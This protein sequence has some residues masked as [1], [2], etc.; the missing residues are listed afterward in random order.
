MGSSECPLTICAVREPTH[1][2]AF[3]LASSILYQPLRAPLPPQPTLSRPPALWHGDSNLQSRSW[4]AS[5][6]FLLAILLRPIS[7]RSITPLTYK[8]LLPPPSAPLLPLAVYGRRNF[9]GARLWENRNFHQIRPDIAIFE[10][11]VVVDKLAASLRSFRSR[12]DDS[13]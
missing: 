6:P 10:R 8:L 9:D 4:T 12:S 5:S 1:R 13:S 2:P 3:C 7:V 11:P